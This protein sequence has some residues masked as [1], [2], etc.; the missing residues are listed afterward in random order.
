[1]VAFVLRVCYSDTK[2]VLIF[3][4]RSDSV[5]NHVQL[6]FPKTVPRQKSTYQGRHK[7]K[8]PFCIPPVSYFLLQYLEL[9]SYFAY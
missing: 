3:M 9:F 6:V 1:M 8:G 4:S 7:M 2:E 5:S